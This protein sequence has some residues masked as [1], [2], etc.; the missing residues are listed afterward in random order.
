[1]PKFLALFVAFDVKVVGQL[2]KRG[3]CIEEPSFKALRKAL[4]EA[5]WLAN[6]STEPRLDGSSSEG[7]TA[8]GLAVQ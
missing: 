7:R 1:M 8:F 5:L 3:E 6:R 2:S 4:C